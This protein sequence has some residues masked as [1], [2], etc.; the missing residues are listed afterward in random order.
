[1]A[2]IIVL[3][4]SLQVLTSLTSAA[5][6]V[7]L[8]YPQ[9]LNYKGR[10]RPYCWSTAPCTLWRSDIKQELSLNPSLYIHTLQQLSQGFCKEIAVKSPSQKKAGSHKSFSYNFCL[11]ILPKIVTGAWSARFD[12]DFLL[13]MHDDYGNGLFRIWKILSKR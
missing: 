4:L 3:H 7:D 8:R 2:G 5:Q 12:E 10:S 1:L 13:P 9:R 11:Q 6:R